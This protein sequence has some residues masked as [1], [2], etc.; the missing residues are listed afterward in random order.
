MQTLINKSE[1]N[2]HIL[3][4][5]KFA[6][7]ENRSKIINKNENLGSPLNEQLEPQNNK[8][9][10]LL[11]SLTK[12]TGEITNNYIKLQNKFEDKEKEYK[13]QIQTIKEEAFQEGF[14]AGKLEAKEEINKENKEISDKFIQSIKKVESIQNEFNKNLKLLQ[15]DLII[16]ALDIAK[17]IILIELKQRSNEIATSLAKSLIKEVKDATKIVLKLNP[18]DKLAV[19]NEFVE[20]DNIQI[21]SDDA[22][23]QG[24]VVIISD[25]ANIQSNIL[26]RFNKIKEEALKKE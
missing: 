23:T 22:I 5:Y 12:K 1:L 14:N 3:S 25:V 8:K 2:K 20:K 10:E 13:T 17:E 6:S 7:I 21:K 4:K 15:E 11:E 26:S 19:E 24:G 18:K 9:N 16:T